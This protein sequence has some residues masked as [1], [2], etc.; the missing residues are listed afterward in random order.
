[1]EENMRLRDKLVISNWVLD[2][3]EQIKED[4]NKLAEPCLDIEEIIEKCLEDI[5]DYLLESSF[6]IARYTIYGNCFNM[7]ALQAFIAYMD[8]LEKKISGLQR[9]CL[10]YEDEPLKMIQHNKNIL[11]KLVY[12][13]RNHVNKSFRKK[14]SPTEVVKRKMILKKKMKFNFQ[15][16]TWN[17]IDLLRQWVNEEDNALKDKKEKISLHIDS[18]L[19]GAYDHYFNRDYYSVLKLPLSVMDIEDLKAFHNI[20]HQYSPKDLED[21]S[22]DQTLI[23]TLKEMQERMEKDLEIMEDA[24]TNEKLK[25]T[26]YP[27]KII[28]QHQEEREGQ[29]KHEVV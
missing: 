26:I 20:I 4:Y 25:N 10:Y 14:P 3:M 6:R 11:Y 18:L 27:F 8:R 7:E 15:Y 1:M 29:F 19:L 23:Q 5:T 17:K 12:Y 21:E 16:T 24:L 28:M 2:Y 13:K 22:L 9:D